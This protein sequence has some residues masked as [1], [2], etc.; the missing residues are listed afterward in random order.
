MVKL[1][2]RKS[3]IYVVGGLLLFFG[4][5]MN[6]TQF[7]YWVSDLENP[8][9]HNYVRSITIKI[10]AGEFGMHK[11]YGGGF[12]FVEVCSHAGCNKK[13]ST[14]YFNKK[15]FIASSQSIDPNY[16]ESVILLQSQE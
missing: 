9:E 11:N 10:S 12:G 4:L 6:I 15:G 8:P 5:C 7:I 16:L 13:Q 1:E 2:V 3:F 14:I